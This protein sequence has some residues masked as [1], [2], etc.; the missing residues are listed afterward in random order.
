M[1][2]IGTKCSSANVNVRV[3]SANWDGNIGR[4]GERGKGWGDDGGG[5]NGREDRGRDDEDETTTVEG[6]EEERREEGKKGVE[7]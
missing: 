1:C 6:W 7:K 5:K 4:Y 3:Y 2:Y